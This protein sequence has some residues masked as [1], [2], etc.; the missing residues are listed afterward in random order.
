M[1]LFNK[2]NYPTIYNALTFKL[3]QFEKINRHSHPFLRPFARSFDTRPHLGL[4]YLFYQ[5]I[6][7]FVYRAVY[8]VSLQTN[9]IV[10]THTLSVVAWY[11][12]QLLE[13]QTVKFDAKNVLGCDFIHLK[14]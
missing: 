7:A 5:E 4:S 8:G 9:Q 3:I 11:H 2:T 12:S 14:Q 13:R 6:S 1:K 10:H